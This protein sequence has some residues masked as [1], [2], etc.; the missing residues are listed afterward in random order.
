HAE[1]D[2]G[3]AEDGVVGG[4]PQVAGQGE[5]QADAEGEAVELGHHRLRA[6]FGGPDVLGEVGELLGGA[7]HEAGNVASGGEGLVAGP[8]DDDDPDGVVGTELPEHT[9]QLVAGG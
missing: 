1:G 6:P 8:T 4:H 5:F 3:Q 9:G 2:L 7:G